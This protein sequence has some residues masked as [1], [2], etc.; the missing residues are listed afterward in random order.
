MF[1]LFDANIWISQFGLRSADGA[2]VRYF[3]RQRQATIAIPEVVQL[4]VEEILAQRLLESKKQIEDG[5]RQLLTVF[6]RL[7]GNPVPTE[8]E[9]RGVVSDIIP[10]FDVPTRR[11][12]FN[13][14]VARSSMTKLLRKIPPSKHKEQ[15]RDGVIWAHCLE[16]LTESDVYF[17]TQDK[18]FY[19]AGDYKK[20]LAR[21][22]AAEMEAVLGEHRVL[23]YK[24]VTELL[25]D[26]RVPIE[27]DN[28]DLF[29]IVVN[30]QRGEIED[31]LNVH[32][33]I[34]FGRVEGDVSY[35]A[36]ECAN[37]VYFRFDFFA[38]VSR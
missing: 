32:E 26:I 31:L 15:F 13:L 6:G 17:V 37:R 4:E 28:S 14:D 21:E 8:D 16:L 5:H 2:A 25:T 36:T 12:P 20:G 34:L 9:I 18:D 10:D 7:Q 30:T 24:S 23:L 11:I 29:H 38:S 27:M 35:F 3:A 19:E 1:I 22:L 33:F